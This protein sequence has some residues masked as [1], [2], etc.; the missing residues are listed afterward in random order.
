M[1]YPSNVIAAFA[2][3][4]V[5][6]G[7]SMA[8]VVAEPDA[9]ENLPSEFDGEEYMATGSLDNV[10]TLHWWN[11]YGDHVLNAIVDTALVAN[12]DLHIAAARVLE[13]QQAH[14]ITRS[15][16]FPGIQAGARGDKQ[17]IPANTGATGSFAGSIPGFPD[18]FE[19]T[20]YSASLSLAYELD[21]W[22]RARANSKAALS[23]WNASRADFIAIRMGIISEVI[24]TYFEIR[25]VQSQIAL[26]TE[27][28]ELLHDR[29]EITDQRYDRGLGTSFEL[30]AIRQSFDD[31]R[32]QL[33][34]VHALEYD[35]ISR[36]SVLLGK[37]MS[38]LETMLGTSVDNKS[39]MPELPAG[40]PSELVQVRP[41]VMAASARMEAARQMI[42]VRRAEQFPSFALT[43][44]GGTQS[45]TL[46][47]LVE[48]SQKFWMLGGSL[49]APVFASGARKAAVKA[50]WAQYEQAALSYE[51]AVL[52]AFRDVSSA[53]VMY[54]GEQERSGAARSSLAAATAS[55][56]LMSKRYT[57][58]VGDYASLVDAKLNE[59]RARTSVSS[60]Q[61]ADAM[62]R[63]SLYRAVGGVW[64]D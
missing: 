20:T 60:A 14:R 50:A 33:P 29:V 15:A 4:F 26:M 28:K 43:A 7:C 48:T 45:R 2:L 36:L 3:S 57:R 35:A 9:V 41:D 8:P 46:S 1:E 42:G 52:T 51:K 19:T 61:R 24:S 21:I 54:A 25:D 64:V 30:Y 31:L 16:Q 37:P 12:L 22:G 18:R 40:L 63:L 10:P 27:Q 49:T 17:D 59:I 62:A 23:N 38:H 56:D 11:G 58:G 44:S 13:V 53:L 34:L 39:V 6:A 55:A 32:A 47:N 5:L